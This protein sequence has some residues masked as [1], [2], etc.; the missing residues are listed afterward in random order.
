MAISISTERIGGLIEGGDNDHRTLHVINVTADD[1]AT[2]TSEPLGLGG[3][4]LLAGLFTV[5]TLTGTS[6]TLNFV[7][8]TSPDGV[9]GWVTA[10]AYTQATGA[11]AETP[12]PFPVHHYVR[13]KF[14]F[15]GT[16]TASSVSFVGKFIK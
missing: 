11:T 5:T 4:T 10:K 8:E 3:L 13:F 6:P 1:I 16:V 7:V 2:V 14:T 15:G 9:T 12:L